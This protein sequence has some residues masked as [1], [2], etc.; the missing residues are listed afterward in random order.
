MGKRLIDNETL[1]EMYKEGKTQ[2]E[3]AEHVGCSQVA[4]SKRLKRLLPPPDLSKFDLSEK[5][6][7]FVLEKSKGKT[8]SQAVMES[9]DVTSLESAKSIGTQLMS[10][11]E[12]KQA[13]EELMAS[14]GL[15]RSYRIGKLKQHVDNRDPNVSLKAIDLANKLDNSYPAAKDIDSGYITVQV[16]IG[17]PSPPPSRKEIDV[18]TIN[19]HGI[20]SKQA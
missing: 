16:N 19:G 12:I 2:A 14:H 4:I 17:I 10:K 11:G 9:Y 13:I 20:G 8:N 7:R 15:T 18:T 3:I 6:Q 5:E 1:V